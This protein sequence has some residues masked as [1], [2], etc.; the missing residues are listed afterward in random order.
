MSTRELS[1]VYNN[2]AICAIAIYSVL[3]EFGYLNY[4]KVALIPPLVFNNKLIAVFS[5][6]HKIRGLEEL[7][8]KKGELLTNFNNQYT[9]F[10]PLMCNALLLLET[11]GV[12]T[13][14]EQGIVITEKE[15]RMLGVGARADKIV[16]CAP[17]I[18]T[19]LREDIEKLYLQLRVIL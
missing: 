6:K 2:E 8:I 14:I 3:K 12:I 15:F 13:I 5:G 17:K 9:N 16:K 7:M 10:L 18:A 1:Y 4:S 19:L 11:M